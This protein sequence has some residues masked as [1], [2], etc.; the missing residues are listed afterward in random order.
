[1][2]IDFDA[3][4]YEIY[5]VDIE[6]QGNEYVPKHLKM[7]SQ[8]NEAFVGYFTEMSN[9]GQIRQITRKV[10]D[11]LGQMPAFDHR[12]LTAYVQRIVETT[13]SSKRVELLTNR[14]YQAKIKRHIKKITDQFLVSEFEKEIQKGEILLQE[15]Y[16]LPIEIK[17]AYSNGNISKSLYEAEAK[18]NNFETNL[19]MR[20]AGLANII[21]WH[22]IDERQKKKAFSINGF[23]N[24]YPDFLIVTKKGTHILLEAKGDHLDGSDS[25]LKLKLGKLWEKEAKQF[26]SDK[27]RYFMVFESKK[28][29]GANDVEEVIE[30]VRAL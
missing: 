14:N 8:F 25:A 10:V 17:P 24:H 20:I 30:I 5:Q 6:K 9:E 2:D 28:L 1:M 7:T 13:D 18:S 16:E 3:I 21:F 27:Y 4:D 22:K 23:L 15:V 19:I 29:D 26:G 12:D 11:A